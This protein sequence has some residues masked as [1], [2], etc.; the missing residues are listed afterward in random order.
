MRSILIV[1]V[2]LASGAAPAQNVDTSVPL[3][4]SPAATTQQPAAPNMPPMADT[5]GLSVSVSGSEVT[6]TKKAGSD[7]VTT[8]VTESPF[9]TTRT[10]VYQGSGGTRVDT[11]FVPAPRA[12][13][14]AE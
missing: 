2:L 7:G 5:T 14:P 6:T 3:T 10:E 12:A 8:Y 9:G 11:S 13:E 4:A 1:A